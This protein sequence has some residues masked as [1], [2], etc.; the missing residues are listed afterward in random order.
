MSFNSEVFY[1]MAKSHGAFDI[2]ANFAAHKHVR[3]EKDSFSIEAMIKNNVLDAKI[4][5]LLKIKQT[6]SF[7]LRF[8]G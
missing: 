3:S 7:F 6:L 1:K 5:R 8:Y 4:F 2:V